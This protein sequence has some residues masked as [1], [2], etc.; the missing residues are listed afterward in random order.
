[1]I[2][3]A[4]EIS[5]LERAKEAFVALEDVQVALNTPLAKRVSMK[6]GGPAEIMVSPLTPKAAANVCKLGWHT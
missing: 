3:V 2:A 1:M 4:V 6:V 5:P